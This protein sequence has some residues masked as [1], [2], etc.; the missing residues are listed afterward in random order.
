M[1]ALYLASTQLLQV[2]FDKSKYTIVLDLDETLFHAFHP[3]KIV[4]KSQMAVA[5]A[6]A[7]RDK[8]R[9]ERKEVSFEEME[10]HFVDIGDPLGRVAILQIRPGLWSFLPQLVKW[11]NVG[12]CSAG[13]RIYV[14]NLCRV[15]FGRLKIRPIFQLDYESGCYEEPQ[16]VT[17]PSTGEKLI[18]ALFKHAYT[19]RLDQIVRYYPFCVLN[20]TLLMDNRQE[21]GAHHPWQLVHVPDFQEEPWLVITNNDKLLAYKSKDTYLQ[22]GAFQSILETIVLW[23]EEQDRCKRQER[24]RQ[25]AQTFI[26]NF[27]SIAVD[28]DDDASDDNGVP[29]RDDSQFDMF[30][31][32]S[33]L[34]ELLPCGTPFSPAGD[35]TVV[36]D[37]TDSSSNSTE[38]NTNN[39]LVSIP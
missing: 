33:D 18:N 1:D 21:N 38:N 7:A 16:F 10:F 37:I 12:V 3:D 27:V 25:E 28:D 32:L 11:Y 39:F 20:K 36:V 24:L 2:S 30:A 22:D 17:H 15:I 5:R 13:G 19:K 26:D 23:E 29:D 9:Y 4:D 6:L 14:A 34:D 8:L 31:D 35:P